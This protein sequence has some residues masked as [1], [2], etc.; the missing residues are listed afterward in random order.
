[1]KTTTVRLGRDLRALL[2]GEAARAGVSVSQYMREAALAR[3]AFAIGA[4]TGAP[5]DLLA[6]WAQTFSK[7]G[8]DSA[9]HAAN[10]QHLIAALAVRES[11]ERRDEA[12]ALRAESRQARR[13]ARRLREDGRPGEGV[14]GDA[15][16]ANDPLSP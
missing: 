15:R 16:T 2:D 11:R 8:D 3:A 7:P 1:M 4:R 14:T 9:E 12:A 6:A 13:Q 5:Y 10:T